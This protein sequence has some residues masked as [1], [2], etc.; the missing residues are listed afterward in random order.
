MT[1]GQT[2]WGNTFLFHS[3]QAEATRL[4]LYQTFERLFELTE[5]PSRAINL[6][7]YVSRAS[8][9]KQGHF[10]VTQVCC[11]RQ[12]GPWTPSI[13]A[14]LDCSLKTHFLASILDC[15]KS[16]EYNRVDDQTWLIYRDFPGSSR[17]SAWRSSPT[18]DSTVI[19]SRQIRISK[20][21]ESKHCL[22]TVLISS[23]VPIDQCYSF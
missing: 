13:F 7:S 1:W 17:I 14:N 2:C 18:R 15:E 23:R 22:C 6:A 10:Q 12:W 8:T 5:R 21:P 20:K 4:S 11:T 3:S 16:T 9:E 19:R